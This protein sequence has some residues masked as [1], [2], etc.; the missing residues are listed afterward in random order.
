VKIAIAYLTKDQP[1]LTKRT[2]PQL[3]SPK[4]DVWWFDGSKTEEGQQLPQQYPWVK[5][6]HSYI[7]GG[8]DAAVAYALTTLLK[9]GYEYIGLCENDV[10]LASDWFES[11]FALFNRGHA[12][13][14]CVGAV[15]PRCYVDRIL[16]Q[17]DGY[18]VCHG[19][20]WGMQ[21]MVRQ[22]AEL[23]LANMRTSYSLE[24]RRTFAKLAY[25][26]IGDWWAFRQN[27]TWLC[28]DWGN[29]RMLAEHGL[30]SL[31]LVPSPVT[32]I[33]QNPP[34]AAQGLAIAEAPLENFRH[35]KQFKLFADN[36]KAVNTSVRSLNTSWEFHDLSNGTWT[37]FAHQLR[38]LG[39]K[40]SGDWKL[41]FL[42][43]FGPFAWEARSTEKS[44]PSLEITVMGS[45]D[46]ICS[47]GEKGGQVRVRDL[48]SRY[49]CSPV[50]P[51]ETLNP[52]VTN[53]VV[54]AGMSYR[55]LKFEALTPGVALYGIRTREPQPYECHE[56]F[57]H[58]WLPGV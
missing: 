44:F 57:N 50:L 41:R 1:E 19:L 46:F 31:A 49:E 42:Q 27:A 3:H 18:A 23:A 45:C 25:V 14:L 35:D 30:A 56:H 32:M 24:N 40:Y 54:P 21:I 55:H 37:Y 20:G 26:D 28:A 34:L 43:G 48:F 7:L 10:F 36:L 22:A 11:T 53:V 12:D 33:G 47:G 58:T 4:Y 29:D 15:S 52:Q 2:F 5:G 8:P 6:I 16:F 9:A 13:G 17:R 51:P 39:G 38:K